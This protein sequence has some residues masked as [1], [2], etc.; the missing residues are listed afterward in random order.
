MEHSNLYLYNEQLREI[1]L[2]IWSD[3]FWQSK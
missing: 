3:M 2:K 1:Y